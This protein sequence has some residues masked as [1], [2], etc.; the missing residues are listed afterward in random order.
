VQSARCPFRVTLGRSGTISGLH[1]AM[2]MQLRAAPRILWVRGSVVRG[3][4]VPAK[5]A[6]SVRADLA[7]L[8][9][10]HRRRCTMRK[11]GLVVL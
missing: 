5:H 4:G 2:I 1:I 9:L 11:F 8:L 10:P 3:S 7:P 6:R